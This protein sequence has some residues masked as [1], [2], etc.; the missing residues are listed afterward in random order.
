[1]P[2]A[3]N[4]D[5]AHKPSPSRKELWKEEL[6]LDGMYAF[7]NVVQLLKLQKCVRKTL[8]ISLRMWCFDNNTAMWL[9]SVVLKELDASTRLFGILWNAIHYLTLNVFI[10][11]SKMILVL[12]RNS[13]L[14]VATSRQNQKPIRFLIKVSLRK[15]LRLKLT[16]ERFLESLYS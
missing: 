1:M 10:P 16:S 3:F 15:K 12:K 8:G 11:F 5:L 4:P 9:F 13:R 7:Y 14:R 6:G 2:M